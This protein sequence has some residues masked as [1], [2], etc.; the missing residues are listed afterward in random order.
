MNKFKKNSATKVTRSINKYLGEIKPKFSKIFTKVVWKKT[1]EILV[2]FTISQKCFLNSIA[3]NTPHY[4]K[5]SNQG[6]LLGKCAQIKKLSTYLLFPFFDKLVFSFLNYLYKKY[7]FNDSD[8]N[9]G[10]A[11]NQSQ[12]LSIS[13][14]VFNKK[15]VAHDGTDIQKPYAKEMENLCVAR[16]GSK[17]SSYSVK[18]G[19]G[20]LA[21]GCTAVYQ[22]MVMPLLLSLYSYKEET[23]LNEKEETKKNLLILKANKMLECFLHIFDRGYDSTSFM[24]YCLNEGVTFLIRATMNRHII[25]ANE[26]H[27]S[28]AD[29]KTQKEKNNIFYDI[30]HVLRKLS[31]RKVN[32]QKYSWFSV[33]F[34]RVFIKG[35][36]YPKNTKD[37]VPVTLISVRITDKEIN[38]IDEDLDNSNKGEREIHFYTNATVKTVID[39]AVLFLC[40]LLR[41]KIEMFFRFVKQIFGLEKVKLQ[42]FKK[43]KNLCKLLPIV[44]YYLYSFFHK[45]TKIEEKRQTQSLKSILN[46]DFSKRDNET[47]L[48]EIFYFCYQRF[49]KQK[50]L[51]HTPDSFARFIYDF[52]NNKV[53]YTH[54]AINYG[55]FDTC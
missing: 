46:K 39:A 28:V 5:K 31:F 25:L 42:K 17:S 40:Y 1:C 44:T 37:I 36:T 14:R 30:K 9:Q 12:S 50:G 7:F 45:F 20:Y 55:F 48:L 33:A 32:D 29:C 22:G 54:Q 3:E 27:E 43:I 4:S 21:E 26:F 19:M 52:M 34:A 18:T 35:E 38:G 16:D 49:C 24:R 41:W 2:G 47:I 6:K 15:I 51:T 23:F 10:S 11:L 8:L 13:E 53:N